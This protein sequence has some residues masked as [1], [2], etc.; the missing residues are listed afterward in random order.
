MSRARNTQVMAVVAKEVEGRVAAMAVE[1]RA[2]G[3]HIANRIRL[4]RSTS[5]PS[6]SQRVRSLG[7]PDP[8]SKFLPMAFL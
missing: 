4:Q 3:I 1:A 6:S 5:C 2:D 8:G 7:T